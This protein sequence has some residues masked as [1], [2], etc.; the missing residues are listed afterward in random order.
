MMLPDYEKLGVFYLGRR[1]DP[2]T[3]TTTSEPLL[4]DSKDLCTHA[5]V[6]GMT[7]SGKTGLCLDL[8]EEAAIDGIP[9]I[10]IDPKGDIGNLALAFPELKPE[11]FLP[12]IDEG[13]ARREG[14]TAEEYAARTAEVWR[15]GLAN[16][17][18]SPERIQRL[19]D[20]AEVKIYTPGS[21]AGHPLTVLRS[22]DAPS[23]E[24]LDDVDLL[25]DRVASATSGLL[26]LVGLQVDPINSREHILVANL[27]QD[28]WSRGVSLTLADLFRGI[29][30]PPFQRVGILDLE[31]FFP[32]AERAK[33]ALRLNN[34][35]ASPSFAGWLEGEPLDVHRLLYGESG[36]PRLSIIS[37][38]HLSESE[39]MFFVTLLLN[40]LIS[41]MRAQPGTSSLRALFYMDEVFG[42][43]PPTADPPSKRPMLTLLKQAR[44]YGLGVVLA[45]QNPVDLDYKGLGNAGTWFLG[46][47]QTERDK[48]R[49][50]EG[51]EGASAQAGRTFDRGEME[52]TI[53]GLGKRIFLMN[54]VHED[55]PVIFETRWAMSYLRGPLTREQIRQLSRDEST[56]VAETKDSETSSAA[57]AAPSAADRALSTAEPL[58]LAWDALQPSR[59]AKEPQVSQ[60]AAL[61]AEVPFV[62]AAIPQRFLEGALGS[63]TG[64]AVHRPAL[65]AV[66]Q[67]HYA[68]AK[69][70]V[71][72]WKRH[73]LLWDVAAIS[74]DPDWEACE[75]LDL[76]HARW[77]ETPP[78][79][80]RFVDLPT[81]FAQERRF[82]S[83]GKAVR[84]FVYRGLPLTVLRHAETKSISEPDEDE[85]HFRVRI[86]RT[87]DDH[88]DLEIEKLKATFKT[89]YDR[90][91]ER[92]TRAEA[93]AEKEREQ[94]KGRSLDSMVSV[95]SSLLSALFGR[96]TA[97]VSNVGRAASA[98]KQLGKAA[99]EKND[100]A[101]AE[102]SVAE[103]RDE[104]DTLVKEFETLTAEIRE[105]TR[106][107]TIEL[108]SITIAPKKTDITVE[109]LALAWVPGK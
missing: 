80:A 10:A 58:G 69:L 6:V 25:R 17:D 90:L 15:E 82:A 74:A 4:Y 24:V 70:S 49:V 23:R 76:D 1:H 107:E 38:A 89:R 91:R 2:A 29:Q 13:A 78:T 75:K 72:C 95:G 21:N 9:A 14:M 16:W 61:G 47:L 42:F 54:N 34:L 68:Q 60:G 39:R 19:R 50:L 27:L 46:R 20:A 98:V 106:A 96:K 45:T 55:A 3:R 32:E 63:S 64:G 62:P 51:L 71:D 67:T 108:E 94:A 101:R 103:L 84:D 37:I 83:L 18:Q 97:S 43:F 92:L 86:K 87:L 33:L 52:R 53:A 12:W 109:L 22:L 65:L 85:S 81:D 77:T 79:G 66:V 48:Q 73:A 28:A 88:R 104:L 26:A 30:L 40:E 102:A 7:G 100:V 93:K 105:R 59:A 31:T 41:W 8:L 35:M 5:V 36:K 56:V 11:D 99:A 44:A 57:T